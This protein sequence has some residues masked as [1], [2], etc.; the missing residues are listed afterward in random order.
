MRKSK[1]YAL[2]ATC[3]ALLL[4]ALAS[5]AVQHDGVTFY[6]ANAIGGSEVTYLRK[7]ETLYLYA[8]AP[9][10]GVTLDLEVWL[11]FPP[12][13][14]IAPE[15]LFKGRMNLAGTVLITRRPIS[16]NDPEGDYAVRINVRDPNTGD[17]RDLTIPFSVRSPIPWELIAAGAVIA[18]VAAGGFIAIRRRAAAQAA[19]LPPPSAPAQPLGVETQVVQPGTIR[20]TAPSGETMMLTAILDAGTK[21]IPLAQLPQ[22]FGRANFVD[23]APREM[24]NA[25]SRRH[26]MIGYDYVRGTFYIQD[27]G[28]TNGTFVN[29]VDIRGKGPVPIKQGD[30]IEVPNAFQARFS[31]R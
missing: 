15:R 10:P 12:A 29:G 22:E 8:T 19:A 28:S 27:L 3:V 30:V 5:A 18:L 17:T 13:S 24:I 21:S 6:I 2:G 31:V 20:I 25:I 26:F 23:V 11:Y 1:S 7:G 9:Q 4:V 14:G 16:D